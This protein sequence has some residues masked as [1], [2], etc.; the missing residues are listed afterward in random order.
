MT[1]SKAYSVVLSTTNKLNIIDVVSGRVLNSIHINGQ[2]IN[3]PIVVGDKCTV[4]VDKSGN[5]SGSIYTL[6][7]G[8]L[9]QTFN[10]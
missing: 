2:I 7:S 8:R 5:R 4:V 6:P 1:Q 9:T 3:G 10:V